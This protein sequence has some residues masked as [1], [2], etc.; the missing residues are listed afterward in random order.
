[1]KSGTN[2]VMSETLRKH[3]ESIFPTPHRRAQ[4]WSQTRL[5]KSIPIYE[6][7]RGKQR[8]NSMRHSAFIRQSLL[9]GLLES[10]NIIGGD[11]HVLIESLPHSP[12]NINSTTVTN[13]KSL[14]SNKCTRK[15]FDTKFS[16][17]EKFS[18]N[19][20]DIRIVWSKKSTFLILGWHYYGLSFVIWWS[21]QI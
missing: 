7:V 13:I 1:M 18:G 2:E 12:P 15:D 5:G 3:I 19:V 9:K 4:V 14:D 17:I 11:S 10:I 20:K 21:R 8:R 6:T 16:V